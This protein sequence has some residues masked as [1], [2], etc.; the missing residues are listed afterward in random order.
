MLKIFVGTTPYHVNINSVH[1]FFVRLIFVA[2]I[3]Y[4]NICTTKISRFTVV[5]RYIQCVATGDVVSL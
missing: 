5:L 3:N 2:A 4:E 1:V